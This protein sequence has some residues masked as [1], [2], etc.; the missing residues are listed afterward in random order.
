MHAQSWGLN[1]TVTP[2]QTWFA[3]L[4]DYDYIVV[5]SGAGGGPLAARLAIGGYS[6]LLLEAGG[7][8]GALLQ[9]QIP[10]GAFL[11]EEVEEMRWDYFVR[12]Y[13]NDTR[14]A[15]EYKTTWETPAG[16]RYVGINPPKG[17][18]PLGILYPRAGT[19]GGCAA[20]NLLITIYPHESDWDNIANLTGDSTWAASNMRK[21]FARLERNEYLAQGTNASNGHGYNG[22]LGVSTTATGLLFG[23]QNYLTQGIAALV[24]TGKIAAQNV[25]TTVSQFLQLL[26]P[27]INEDNRC[28]RLRCRCMASSI[29]NLQQSPKQP[30]RF[31]C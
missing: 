26:P 24:A 28:T 6:V 1:F 23:D 22:W 15:Q 14:Q 12:H 27:D 9:E 18:K 17:S 29:G 19:L 21:Y 13:A 25:I 4:Q 10:G 2:K 16:A 31:S 8:A 11:S 30:A 3:A 5:G 20:H 7:D